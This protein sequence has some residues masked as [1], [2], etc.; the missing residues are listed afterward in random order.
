MAATALDPYPRRDA[1]MRG[2]NVDV[3]KSYAPDIHFLPESRFQCLICEARLGVFPHQPT[4]APVHPMSSSS[5]AILHVAT[6]CS[7]HL[8]KEHLSSDWIQKTARALLA[9]NNLKLVEPPA[10]GQTTLQFVP[11]PTTIPPMPLLMRVPKTGHRRIRRS[12]TSPVHRCCS[13]ITYSEL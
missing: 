12:L 2:N 5:N 3:K 7:G 4:P 9:K 10:K 11:T 13:L 1:V 6:C 8:V